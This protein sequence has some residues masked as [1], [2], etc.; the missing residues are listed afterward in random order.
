MTSSGPSWDNKATKGS[1][2]NDLLIAVIHEGVLLVIL[3]MFFAAGLFALK[4][5]YTWARRQTQDKGYY[6]HFS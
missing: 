2:V 3:P 1:Q 6:Q 5:R 4:R